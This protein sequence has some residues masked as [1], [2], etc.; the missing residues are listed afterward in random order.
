MA[1]SC[2]RTSALGDG[3]NRA[4]EWRMSVVVVSVRVLARNQAR[5]VISARR[6]AEVR[7]TVTGGCIAS[8]AFGKKGRVLQR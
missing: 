7:R 8:L 2:A 5:E 4:R 6:N 3:V 1:A